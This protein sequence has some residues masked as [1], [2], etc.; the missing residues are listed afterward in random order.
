MQ[1]VV[2]SGAEP[3]RTYDLNAGTKLSI[4]RQSSNQIVISDEQVSRRHAEVESNAGG[5]VVN[6]LSSSNGTFVNGT[7]ISSPIVLKPGDTLQVGTTVLKLIDNQ[8]ATQTIP[9]GLY[10][11]SEAT[12]VAGDFKP[13]AFSGAGSSGFSPRSEPPAY[14]SSSN[15]SGASF[16]APPAQDFGFNPPPPSQSS[17]SSYGSP[18]D[19]SLD[20][21]KGEVGAGSYNDQAAF[22]PAQPASAYSQPG[23]GQA[24]QGGGYA[25]SGYGQMPEQAGIYNQPGYGQMPGQAAN[26]SPQMGYDQQGA[27]YGQPGYPA[28]QSAYGRPQ[29]QQAVKSARKNNV[30]FIG[31]GA[32]ILVLIILA[33]LFVFLGRAGASGDLPTPTNSTR[34]E[35][36]NS[37]QLDLTKNAKSFK[38]NLYTSSDNVAALGSLYKDKM[39]A[40]GYTLDS[41]STDDPDQK[42]LVFT[43]GDKA[44]LVILSKLTKSSI[45]SIEQQNSA[46]VGK[47]KEGDTMVLLGEGKT[48]DL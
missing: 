20:F 42:L 14:G 28:N 29:P 26:Y 27:P 16:S 12:Q 6:D 8:A 47:L 32:V 46:L 34:Y 33:L 24:E 19:A 17:A 48:A 11:A 30:L 5:V 10:A 25:Q 35:I 22:N 3:G 15:S 23:Y 40:K 37:D 38:F 18:S 41:R 45:S 2:Q 39:K 43:N 4:G 9:P 44:A 31:I 21:G 7:R 36:S 13:G 1:L